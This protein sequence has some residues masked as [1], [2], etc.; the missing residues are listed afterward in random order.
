MKA[1]TWQAKRT[2]SV[3]EVPDPKIIEPTDAIIRVTSSAICGSD[4]HLYEV[5]VPFMDKGDVI[6]Q[7]ITDANHVLLEVNPRMDTVRKLAILADAAKYD[8]S[9][10][11]SG[12]ARSKRRGRPVSPTVRLMRIRSCPFGPCV[13]VALRRSNG[14]AVLPDHPVQ[15]RIDEVQPRRRAPVAEQARLDMLGLQRFAQERIIEK[16][17]LADR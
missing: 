11:S 13:S 17:D 8:A 9:C 7:A 1:L 5:L 2:V 4:L 12:A 15:V 16:I 6:G 14:S 10:A 3:E